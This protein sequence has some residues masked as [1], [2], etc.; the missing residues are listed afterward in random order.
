M[1]DRVLEKVI[2]D[3]AR[4]GKVPLAEII[5]RAKKKVREEK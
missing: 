1:P 5:E 2:I 3:Y 4:C